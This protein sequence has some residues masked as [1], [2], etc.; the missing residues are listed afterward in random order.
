MLDDN[1]DTFE[2][3]PVIAVDTLSHVSH[4]AGLHH[5]S[6]AG[7]YPKAVQMTTLAVL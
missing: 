2:T 3:L 7:T 1:A 6:N 4:A 5:F